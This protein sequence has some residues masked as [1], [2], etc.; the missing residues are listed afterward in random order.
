MKIGLAIDVSATARCNEMIRE[1]AAKHL[2]SPGQ[3]GRAGSSPAVGTT[4]KNF[5]YSFLSRASLM[6]LADPPDITRTGTLSI[7]KWLVREI[8]HDGCT[9]VAVARVSGFRRM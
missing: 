3:C 9:W 1:A 2:N 4:F 7:S 8:N 6:R 5:F